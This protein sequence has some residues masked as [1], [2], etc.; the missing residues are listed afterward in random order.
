MLTPESARNA[1]VSLGLSQS[2]VAEDLDISR[3]YLSQFEN[4]KMALDS[5]VLCLLKDYYAD[6]G[7]VLE[8]VDS[9]PELTLEK[10]IERLNSLTS[11]ENDLSEEG[12]D[13]FSHE[14]LKSIADAFGSLAN[15]AASDLSDKFGGF[16]IYQG[17]QVSLNL[18]RNSKDDVD[19]VIFSLNKDL[20]EL[21]KIYKKDV[22]EG[23]TWGFFQE[24]PEYLIRSLMASA[25][26]KQM[27]LRRDSFF[28]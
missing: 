2:K 19:N 18:L 28:S 11:G 9:D 20:K 3:V 26:N 23:I 6:K 5:P 24:D 22:T 15:K 14:H 17:H 21:E 8:E 16:T 25:F 13:R 4:G 10:E 1:R 7:V 27:A 12:G